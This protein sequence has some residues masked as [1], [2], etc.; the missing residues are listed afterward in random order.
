MEFL[1]VEHQMDMKSVAGFFT[2]DYTKPTAME[3]TFLH[4]QSHHPPAVFKSIVLGE[5]VRLRRLN[6]P[7]ETYHQSLSKLRNKCARSSFHMNIIDDLLSQASTWTERFKQKH[8]H[9]VN[10]PLV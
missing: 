1:D 6:E 10:K 5:A 8:F 9:K 2:R 7:D 4:G 3:R